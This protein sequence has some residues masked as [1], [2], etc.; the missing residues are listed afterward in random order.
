M[1]PYMK[2]CN[3]P[4]RYQMFTEEYTYIIC[5]YFII[6]FDRPTVYRN[7]SYY[8]EFLGNKMFYLKM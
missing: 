3:F 8:Y 4:V 1:L 6:I 7:D 5:L 2:T